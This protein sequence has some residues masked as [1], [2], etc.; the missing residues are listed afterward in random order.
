MNNTPGPWSSSEQIGEPDC[1][2][3]AQVFGPD[4]MSLACLD[5][6]ED[7]AVATANARLMAVAPELLHA[8]K[9]LLRLSLPQDVSGMAMV[10]EARRIVRKAQGVKDGNSTT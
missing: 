10:E 1:C 3:T 9:L 4:G 8:C 7:P 5:T 6:T 2:F